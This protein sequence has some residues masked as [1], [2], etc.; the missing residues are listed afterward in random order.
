MNFSIRAKNPQFWVT[1]LLAIFTPV[2]AYF[3]LSADDFTSWGVVFKVLFEAISNPYICG[4]MV[5]GAWTTVYNPTTSGFLD[6]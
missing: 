1:L 4:L 2:L 5:V 3:G 6:E